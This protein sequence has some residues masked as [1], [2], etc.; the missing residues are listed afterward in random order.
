MCGHC[1]AHQEFRDQLEVTLG[2]MADAR[3]CGYCHGVHN[4][5]LTPF[6]IEEGWPCPY[7]A[8]KEAFAKRI[9]IVVKETIDE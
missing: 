4:M 1:L 7:D 3:V 2:A 5:A 6:P 8:S 9:E